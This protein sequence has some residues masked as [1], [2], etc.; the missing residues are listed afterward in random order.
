MP[1]RVEVEQLHDEV[2]GSWEIFDINIAGFPNHIFVLGVHFFVIFDELFLKAAFLFMQYNSMNDLWYFIF[3][4]RPS[5]LKLG[6]IV[7][8]KEFF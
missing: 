4:E 8:V 7:E 2:I 1:H 5:R 3:I 6:S